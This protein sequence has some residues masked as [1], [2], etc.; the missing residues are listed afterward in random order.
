MPLSDSCG[1]RLVEEIMPSAL[2]YREGFNIPLC[3]YFG[4][5]KDSASPP[6][7]SGNLRI[8]GGGV[9]GRVGAGEDGRTGMGRRKLRGG[10]I[11]KKSG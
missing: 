11:R 7:F 8:D 10:W 5:K 6:I 9:S 1:G 2:E 4:P 3:G